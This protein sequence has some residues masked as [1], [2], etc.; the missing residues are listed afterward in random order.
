MSPTC[1]FWAHI[2][3]VAVGDSPAYSH[4]CVEASLSCCLLRVS[5][6][7]GFLGLSL[8]E[9]WPGDVRSGPIL[10]SP[11]K[12]SHIWLPWSS[13]DHQSPAA[14]LRFQPSL[15]GHIG[16]TYGVGHPGPF[17]WKYEV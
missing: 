14:V 16:K 9:L 5:G 11:R 8:A 4:T 12:S 7:A 2:Q 1:E 10:L 17:Y 3:T 13:Y 6:V 15:H